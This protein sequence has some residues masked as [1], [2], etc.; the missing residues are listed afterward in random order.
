MK[1]LLFEIFTKCLY[2]HNLYQIDGRR[3]QD[4]QRG[5]N[6]VNF[7]DEKINP[8]QADVSFLYPLKISENLWVYRNGT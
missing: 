4:G 5:R 2:Q 3:K 1:N 7:A 6:K 8:F